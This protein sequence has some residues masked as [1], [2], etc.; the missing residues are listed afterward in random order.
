M[1]SSPTDQALHTVTRDALATLVDAVAPQL[2]WL[3]ETPL[4]HL[5][6]LEGLVDHAR[7]VLALDP[8]GQE[9]VAIMEMFGRLAAMVGDF[10]D[11]VH[12]DL[13]GQERRPGVPRKS[14]KE[15]LAQLKLLEALTLGDPGL[16]AW[17]A[18]GA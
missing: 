15:M 17:D 9:A 13:T 10:A 7:A 11:Y 6:D 3:R 2:P 14:R 12:L 18:E 4:A 1:S 8:A 16:A 5:Y